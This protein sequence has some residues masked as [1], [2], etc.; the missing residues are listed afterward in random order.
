M[1]GLVETQV[2]DAVNALIEADS[3]LASSVREI[4]DQINQMEVKIDDELPAIHRAPPAGRVRPAADHQHL[5]VGRS[6]WSASATR[7][8]KIAR[9]CHS[10]VRTRRK[11]LRGYVEV[12]HRLR[13]QRGQHGCAMRWTRSPASTP[14]ARCRSSQDDEVIDT[15]FD[16]RSAQADHLHDG[17]PAHD[18]AGSEI[19]W[20]LR[21]LERIG[22]HARNISEL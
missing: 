16:D 12:R 19:I 6:T 3:S 18:L 22:D 17:R 15:E 13:R 21:S 10:A 20:V 5:Q 14:I 4:D 2:N 1:G 7:R 11:R 9:T 8:R